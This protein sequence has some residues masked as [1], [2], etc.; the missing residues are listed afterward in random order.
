MLKELVKRKV[1]YCEGPNPSMEA[2]TGFPIGSKW[3]MPKPTNYVIADPV[4]E[5][6][7]YAPT[8]KEGKLPSTLKHNYAK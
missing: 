2:L 1:P 5:F 6:A 7:F 8:I 3:Q 4:N